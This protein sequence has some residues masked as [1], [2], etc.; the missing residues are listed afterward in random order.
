MIPAKKI[1]WR[2]PYQHKLTISNKQKSLKNFLK[3]ESLSDLSN[4]AIVKLHE[5]LRPLREQC[6]QLIYSK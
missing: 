5:N 3:T 6:S 4:I 1:L 2:E